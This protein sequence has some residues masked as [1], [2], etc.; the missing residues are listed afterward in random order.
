MLR[1]RKGKDSVKVITEIFNRG[2][3]DGTR[4]KI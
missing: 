4:S 1:E 2:E 3:L